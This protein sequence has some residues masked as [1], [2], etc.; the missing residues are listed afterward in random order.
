[1]TRRTGK[2]ERRSEHE[3]CMDCMQD[4][5]IKLY[6]EQPISHGKH[7]EKM[8]FEKEQYEIMRRLRAKDLTALANLYCVI[9]DEK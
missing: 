2:G 3:F 4:V 5:S 6:G 8:S 7:I 1:M 9:L